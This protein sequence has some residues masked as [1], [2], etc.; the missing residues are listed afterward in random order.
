VII[1]LIVIGYV[2]IYFLRAPLTNAPREAPLESSGLLSKKNVM[3]FTP[4]TVTFLTGQAMGHFAS[5]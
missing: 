5:N 3:G 4:D 2:S 1:F